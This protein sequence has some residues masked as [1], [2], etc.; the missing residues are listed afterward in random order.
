MDILWA[1]LV[2]GVTVD[3]EDNH[4]LGYGSPVT[5]LEYGGMP[6]R[7]GEIISFDNPIFLLCKWGRLDNSSF[8]DV[9]YAASLTS[10]DLSNAQMK[11]GVS[12]KEERY[13]FVTFPPGYYDQRREI[14]HTYSFVDGIYCFCR[15]HS[16]KET[17]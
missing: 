1:Q 10:P 13:F 5:I 2:D 4:V 12:G 7:T 14:W 9:Y 8:G 17:G 16:K 3:P 11:V 6:A 15:F